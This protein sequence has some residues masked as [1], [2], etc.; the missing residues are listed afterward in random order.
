MKDLNEQRT[1]VKD[2]VKRTYLK[3][4]VK[5]AF[6]SDRLRIGVGG[7]KAVREEDNRDTEHM[8]GK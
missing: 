6:T 4:L 1:F 7:E 5:R 3:D 2:L 8:K